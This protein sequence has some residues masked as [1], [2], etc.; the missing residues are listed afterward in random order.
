MFG[1]PQ[2]QA[3]PVS[4]LYEARVTVP[5]QSESERRQALPRALGQVLIKLTGDRGITDDG[6][7]K[8]I[9]NNAQD[10]LQQYRYLEPGDNEESLRLLASFDSSA[11]SEALR[12]AGIAAWG[13]ER[14]ATLV[15]LAVSDD[16]GDH[17]VGMEQSAPGGENYLQP[18]IDHAQR[19][20]IP[21]LLPLMDLE[22][23]RE[24]DA[25]D[26]RD[27]SVSRIRAASERYP[28]DIVIAVSV[29]AS[30]DSVRARWTQLSRADGDADWTTSGDSVDA[31]LAAGIDRLADNLAQRYAPRTLAGEARRLQLTVTAIDSLEDYAR[32]QKYLAGLSNVSRVDVSRVRPD[33]VVFEIESSVDAAALDQTIGIGRTLRADGDA[34]D[35]DGDAGRRYRLLP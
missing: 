31:A 35:S 21:L 34:T 24:L 19:R 4:G 7:A 32:A 30:G 14:P 1:L 12:R 10:Y 2:L 3:M 17:L 16:A 27:G 33:S 8:P 18:I 26:V 23:A 15:W 6:R 5:D 20:G 11:V 29:G 28:A 25:A 9:L 22:D 13:R